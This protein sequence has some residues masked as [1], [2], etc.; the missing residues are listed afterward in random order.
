MQRTHIEDGRQPTSKESTWRNP[1]REEKP[2]ST[3]E[4]MERRTG[5]NRPSAYKKRRRIIPNRHLTITNTWSPMTKKNL[6]GFHRLSLSTFN[7]LRMNN[8]TTLHA[9]CVLM[10]MSVIE[11]TRTYVKICALIC[12]ICS[13]LM[14]GNLFVSLYR[15]RQRTT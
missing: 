14:D 5:I 4:K 1:W 12:K 2:R 9:E 11:P 6:K 10:W 8:T 7:F 15:V 3:N 13:P